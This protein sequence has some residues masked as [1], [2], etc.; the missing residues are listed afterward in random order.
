MRVLFYAAAGIL[1]GLLVFAFV[2]HRT[3]PLPRQQAVMELLHTRAAM[4]QALAGRGAALT[5]QLRAF[6]E[7]VAGDRDFAMKLLVETDRAAPEVSEFARRFMAAMDFALLEIADSAGVLLSCGHFPAAAGNSVASKTAL[8]DTQAVFLLDNIRGEEALTMQAAVTVTLG[9]TTR[10]TCGGG[11]VVDQ[12]FLDGLAPPPAVRVLLR[13]GP[14]SIGLDS[15]SSM[16]AVTDNTIIINDTTYLA[17][18]LPL[19]YRGEG[20]AP[21]LLLA[22]GLPQRFSLF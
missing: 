9:E 16:S 14:H 10:L 21:E 7:Q 6:A 22:G 3:A 13:A 15:V 4:E 19:V 2:S 11:W 18:A 12:T 17:A 1:G 8:L 20:A 5:R